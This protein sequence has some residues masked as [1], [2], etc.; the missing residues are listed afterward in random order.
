MDKWKETAQRAVPDEIQAQLTLLGGTIPPG[1]GPFSGEPVFKL[2]WGPDVLI[3]RNGK[4]RKRFTLRQRRRRRHYACTNEMFAQLSAQIE[5]QQEQSRSAYMNLD[6]AKAFE[7]PDLDTFIKNNFT[8]H[9][10]YKVFD[11]DCPFEGLLTY[12]QFPRYFRDLDYLEQIGSPYYVVLRWMPS[13][14]L[15]RTVCP[16]FPTMIDERKAWEGMRFTRGYYPELGEPIE[17][18]ALGPY[19]EWGCYEHVFLILEDENNPEITV[20]PSE[21]NT[22]SKLQDYLQMRD[23]VR[24]KYAESKEHRTAQDLDAAV[25]EHEQ[26]DL[27]WSVWFDD[28]LKD[29]KPAFADTHVTVPQMPQGESL[30]KVVRN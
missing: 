6:L 9:L 11:P 5:R 1:C 7:V 10:D 21:E 8:E 30:I 17:L 25:A 3:W 4:M 12:P 14:A 20:V 16:Q 19:P 22:I 24:A 18:D 23:A 27:L 2:F 13:P 28:V 29:A 15:R 26:T